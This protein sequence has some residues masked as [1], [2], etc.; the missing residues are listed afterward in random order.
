VGSISFITLILGLAP[1]ALCL[2]LLRGLS[3]IFCAVLCLFVADFAQTQ[4]TSLKRQ[5][6]S[7]MQTQISTTDTS[8]LGSGLL[9]ETNPP[10][11]GPIDPPDNTGGGETTAPPPPPTEEETSSESE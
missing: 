9:F 3:R 4:F 7:Y 10:G 5:K 6:D 1:Q 2:R 11:T 8:L